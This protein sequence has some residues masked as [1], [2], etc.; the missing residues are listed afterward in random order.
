MHLVPDLLP[1][2]DVTASLDVYFGRQHIEPG[3]HVNS[4]QSVTAPRLQVQVFNRGER[5]VTVAVVN[6]DVP[7]VANDT[8]VS[9][10]HFLAS[11][12]SL[13]PTETSINL[14]RLAADVQLI[15]PWTPAYAQKGAPYQR[16]A[17]FILEQ[18][19]GTQVDISAATEREKAEGF[20]LRSFVDRHSLTPT[21]ASLFRTQW[22]DNTARVMQQL[23]VPGHDVEFKRKKVEPLP[24]KRL[25]GSR[26]R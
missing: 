3:A 20:N 24:Y 16:M 5:L 8:F 15:L 12:I 22:D 26:F 11:N 18:P 21:S 6:P 14:Q 1:N 17:I 10:C 25:P 4:L 2:I 23:G 7:D 19:H 9:R 13:S